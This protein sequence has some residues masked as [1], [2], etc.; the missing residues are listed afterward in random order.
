MATAKPR[1]YSNEYEG[2][3]GQALERELAES[4]T[5]NKHNLPPTWLRCRLHLTIW[6]S[7]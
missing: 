3:T 1:E 6:L 5:K 4:K 7:V 2:V